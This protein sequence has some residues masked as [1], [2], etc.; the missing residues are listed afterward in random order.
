MTVLSVLPASGNVGAESRR[1]VV[2]PQMRENMFAQA[3]LHEVTAVLADPVRSEMFLHTRGIRSQ[4]VV[5]ALLGLCD[6]V[7]LL[8][9]GRD[10]QEI[11][12]APR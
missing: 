10:R 11:E 12:Q 8:E 1:P 7:R 4:A 2:H 5:N 9:R 6:A 3:P